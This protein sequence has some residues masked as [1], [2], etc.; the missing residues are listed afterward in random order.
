M[1][2]LGSCRGRAAEGEVGLI[3]RNRTRW[4]Q[5]FWCG[6]ICYLWQSNTARGMGPNPNRSGDDG[7]G[8]TSL[9]DVIV[10]YPTTAHRAMALGSG[11]S[12]RLGSV[13]DTFKAC[14]LP[15]RIGTDGLTLRH[16]DTD[17]S[18]QCS[19]EFGALLVRPEP[20]YEELWV[21]VEFVGAAFA[22]AKPHRDDEELVDVTGYVIDPRRKG[23]VFAVDQD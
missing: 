3:L 10:P 5:G 12:G 21:R 7:E 4:H 20:P 13:S 23:K 17:V 22:S 16:S 19:V 18:P 1:R 15:W 6:P 14:T 9:I 8:W 11:R 2:L